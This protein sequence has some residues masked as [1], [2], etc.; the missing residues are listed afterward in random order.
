MAYQLRDFPLPLRVDAEG[1]IRVAGSRLLIDM[2]IYGFRDGDSPERIARSFPTLQVADAYAIIAY[3]LQNKS[4]LDAYIL[5]R[6]AAG[7]RL[8][9]EIEAHCPPHGLRE[10][11]LERQRRQ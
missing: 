8:R 2:I 1:T 5:E 9:Q 4:E 11:L 6:E 7:E 10:R 3:Y